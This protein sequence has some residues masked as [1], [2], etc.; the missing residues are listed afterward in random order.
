MMRK[1]DIRL[2]NIARVTATRAHVSLMISLL[3]ND[4]RPR[5]KT[6]AAQKNVLVSK[7]FDGTIACLW[8]RPGHQLRLFG[9]ESILVRLAVCHTFH[10]FPNHGHTALLSVAGHFQP[11][12]NCW[13]CWHHRHRNNPA[14]SMVADGLFSVNFHQVG[15]LGKHGLCIFGVGVLLSDLLFCDVWF[16][17]RAK[18]GL[19]TSVRGCRRCRT[20]N[21]IQIVVKTPPHRSTNCAEISKDQ[22]D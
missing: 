10:A 6:L 2:Y 9:V 1:K 22:T 4:R 18:V 11:K 3:I 20:R 14:S 8:R 17:Y 5:D 13:V 19:S 7:V 12:C 16:S 21:V 15:V